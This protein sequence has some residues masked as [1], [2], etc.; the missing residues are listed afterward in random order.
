VRKIKVKK[1]PLSAL[2]KFIYFSCI[3][4][5]IV[6]FG[7]I[8]WFFLSFSVNIAF[9]SEETVAA[10]PETMV[11]C[12]MPLLA[13]PIAFAVP[14]FKMINDKQ[15]I[16]GNKKFKPKWNDKIEK[17]YPLFTEDFKEYVWPQ[18]RKKAI[19][20]IVI[21]S[22]LLIISIFV[23]LLALYPRTEL[24]SNHNL[25][26][27]NS[28]N[29]LTDQKNINDADKINISIG[30]PPRSAKYRIVLSF[31][32]EDQTS[33]VFWIHSFDEMSTVETLEYM[34]QLKS[35]FKDKCYIKGADKIQYLLQDTIHTDKEK[36]LLYKLFDYS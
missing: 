9:L 3:M 23:S 13:F 4:L 34:I 10:E 6:L 32:F 7:F 30:K 36:E 1:A 21:V 16:L 15:P 22:I 29:E 14:I 11:L 27:Y 35:L 8:I 2:D 24:D 18:K 25:Y 20:Y 26:T 31:Y 28:F 12:F 19:R 33:Y 17:T 5:N